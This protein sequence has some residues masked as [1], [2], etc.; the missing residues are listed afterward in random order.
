MLVI[1]IIKISNGVATKRIDCNFCSKLSTSNPSELAIIL[2]GENFKAI[3]ISIEDTYE[4]ERKNTLNAI[5][6]ILGKVDIPLIVS[7]YL[8]DDDEISEL[9]KLGCYRV[10]LNFPVYENQDRVRN[11][12][13][14]FSSSKIVVRLNILNKMIYDCIWKELPFDILTAYNFVKELGIQRILLSCYSNKEE[15]IIDFE[16]LKDVLSISKLRHTFIGGVNN[17]DYLLKI[18]QYEKLGLDSVVIGRALFENKFKCQ[19]LWRE[20]EKYLD[21][22]GPTRRI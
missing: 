12:V 22:L 6:D 21:D 16:Y 3:H 1:P 17:L 11:L 5:K 7:A 10:V 14:R 15:R 19:L 20:N 13:K 8:F 9:F 4:N 2:R 18:S